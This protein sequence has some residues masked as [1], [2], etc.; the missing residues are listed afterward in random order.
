MFSRYRRH[1]L[2]TNKH[3]KVFLLSLS[4]RILLAHTIM[5]FNLLWLNIYITNT[6]QILTDVVAPGRCGCCA[7]EY[8]GCVDVPLDSHPLSPPGTLGTYIALASASPGCGCLHSAAPLSSS[9]H[10]YSGLLHTRLSSS[11]V[12]LCKKNIY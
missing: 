8:C 4:K 2:N 11:S 1:T 6:K 9:G 10:P 3:F 7:A 12:H 5:L